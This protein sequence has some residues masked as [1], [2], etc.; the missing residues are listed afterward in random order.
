MKYLSKLNLRK[1]FRS[2]LLKSKSILG[3]KYKQTFRRA[4]LTVK[5][6]MLAFCDFESEPDKCVCYIKM[7]VIL[8]HTSAL[9][10]YTSL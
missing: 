3:S 6:I 5:F 4:C 7:Y 1:I 9:L 10:Q 8:L 2:H